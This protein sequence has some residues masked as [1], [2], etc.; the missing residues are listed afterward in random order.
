MPAP[1]AGLEYPST[2]YL[3]A[4]FS[5]AEL[6]KTTN[7]IFATNAKQVKKPKPKLRGLQAE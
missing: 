4:Y 1:I 6:K 7:P 2:H 5:A 3:R